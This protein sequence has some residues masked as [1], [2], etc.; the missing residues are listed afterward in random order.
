MFHWE[1]LP[2]PHHLCLKFQ[3]LID[4]LYVLATKLSFVST[5]LSNVTLKRVVLEA[6]LAWLKTRQ[7]AAPFCPIRDHLKG[8]VRSARSL[9]IPTFSSLK[10]INSW[11]QGWDPSLRG[12]VFLLL[13]CTGFGIVR[14]MGMLVQLLSKE[15]KKPHRVPKLQPC[16]PLARG[17]P[18]P[19]HANRDNRS[20][21]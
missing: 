3:S 13:A 6:S 14:D 8:L 4:G 17:A 2:D 11:Q 1:F 15:G 21:N 20:A 10:P 7:F 19:R 12:R 9:Y 16:G 5:M 18:R